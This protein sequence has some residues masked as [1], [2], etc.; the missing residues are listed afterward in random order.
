M[1]PVDMYSWMLAG[2]L[3]FSINFRRSTTRIVL[4]FKSRLL[5]TQL[6]HQGGGG[7]PPAEPAIPSPSQ[8][9]TT[10]RLPTFM[11]ADQIPLLRV[12]RT[13]RPRPQRGCVLGEPADSNVNKH[14]QPTNPSAVV[15]PVLISTLGAQHNSFALATSSYSHT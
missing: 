5:R 14:H 12:R 1:F 4:L 15:C 2:Q 10:P 8:V 3:S 7:G 6:A 9:E 13:P 11:R